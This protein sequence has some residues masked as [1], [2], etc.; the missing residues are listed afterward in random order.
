MSSIHISPDNNTCRRKMLQLFFFSLLGIVLV[1]EFGGLTALARELA[2]EGSSNEQSTVM[3]MFFSLSEA[4]SGEDV[5]EE[6]GTSICAHTLKHAVYEFG[7]PDDDS[8]RCE[9]K[10]EGPPP[11]T[12]RLHWFV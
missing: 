11:V 4:Q 9:Y 8:V 7:I 3:K 10:V 12:V 6:M 2:E 5:T 1:P